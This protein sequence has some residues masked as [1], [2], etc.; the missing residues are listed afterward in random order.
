MRQKVLYYASR[1]GVE[2]FFD[3]LLQT[4]AFGG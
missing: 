1:S 3:Q 2:G 4:L